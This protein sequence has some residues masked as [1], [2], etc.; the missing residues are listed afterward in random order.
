MRS[1]WISLLLA[2]VLVVTGPS[3]A[4][5]DTLV[6]RLKLGD[7]LK[8]LSDALDRSIALALPTPIAASAG[9]VFRFDPA[10]GAYERETSVA[11]QLFLERAQPVGRGI[12]NLSV[13]YQRVKIDS[14]DGN[15]IERL[16]DHG[17]KFEGSVV[18]FP[19]FSL[20]LETHQVAF[21]ATYG[22]TEQ[23][24]VN[25]TVPVLFTELRNHLLQT[26]SE[27]SRPFNTSGTAFGVGDVLVRGK[28]RVLER[29]WL[30]SALGLVLRL[31]SGNEDD[32]QGTGAMEVAP[33]LYLTG[34][35]FVPDP[36]IRL[37]PYLNAGV[38]FN[39][40][41][42]GASEPR[43]GIGIDAGFVERLTVAVAVLGRHPL[44]RLAPAGVLSFHH[45][46]GPDRQLLGIRGDRPDIYDFS[47]GGRVNLW[48]DTVMA[49]ANATVPLNQDSARS[50][51]IPT[52]GLEA[53]F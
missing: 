21:S 38:N 29:D 13:S 30:Q 43:W 50:Q 51:I 25:L 4:A 28:Y 52:A 48:R 3:R 17:I 33:L 19:R 45:V 7:A 9:I 32:F 41:D 6:G 24:D 14:F 1:P 18:N 37:L 10:T 26:S 5:A 11:G 8:P 23:A 49:F 27:G 31:P 53:T 20:D 36:R 2:S 34:R 42:V 35:S 15:D 12:W 40:D 47:L 22:L 16:E 44:R 46:D 39:S